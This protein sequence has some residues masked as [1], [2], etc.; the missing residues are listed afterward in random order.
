MPGKRLTVEEREQIKTMIRSGMTR[1][2]IHDQTGRSIPVIQNIR[3]ELKKE[4]SFDN[5]HVGGMISKGI[6]CSPLGESPKKEETKKPKKLNLR[7]KK[8]VVRFEGTRTG[9]EYV[10]SSDKDELIIRRDDLEFKVGFACIEK[11]AEE[12]LDIAV[13]A[14]NLKKQVM[15]I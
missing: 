6:P 5:W 9:F 7:V 13:E 4:E 11:F 10:V 12:I 2:Q 15:D 3:N 14:D 1:Y 8:K